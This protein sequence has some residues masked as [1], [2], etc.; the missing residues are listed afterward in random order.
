MNTTFRLVPNGPY[1]Y[2]VYYHNNGIFVGWFERDVD[3]YFY[4]AM[5][6]KPT[7][8]LIPSHHLKELSDMLEELNEPWDKIVEQS[9]DKANKSGI[10]FSL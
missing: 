1:A 2:R 6:N 8:G 4:Y 3:G 10:Q 5:P 7:Q 9:L